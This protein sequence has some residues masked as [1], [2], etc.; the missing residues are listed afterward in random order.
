MVGPLRVRRIERERV[1]I[2]GLDTV[3][4][5]TVREPWR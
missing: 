5:L 4:T 1:V 3:W 2:A